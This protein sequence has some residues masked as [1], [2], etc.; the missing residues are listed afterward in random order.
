[1]V[2]WAAP[3]REDLRQIFDYIARDSRLY[4]QRVTQDIVEKT[5]KLDRFPEIGRIVPELGEPNVHEL[6]IAPYRIIYEIHPEMIVVLAVI[7]GRRNLLAEEIATRKG[8]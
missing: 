5:E 6:I 7:H 1:M 4:A 3:A 2:K 8:I